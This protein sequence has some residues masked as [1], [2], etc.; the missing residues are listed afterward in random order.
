MSGQEVSLEPFTLAR[1]LAFYGEYVADPAMLDHPF[2]FDP[3]WAKRY[4]AAKTSDK[5]HRVFAVCLNG[6][7]IG[8]I[9]LKRI[10]L[11]KR[12]AT[13]SVHFSRDE[14]KNSGYGTRAEALALDY[15]FKTL[16]LSAVLADT[17]LR[18]ARSQH[19]LE[20]NGFVLTGEDEAFKY[21]HLDREKWLGG[22]APVR[23]D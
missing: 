12:E 11:E 3:E 13:L 4:H 18:N 21:Y 5:A 23:T 6:K 7:P 17:V 2:T 9:Q 22:R 16:G 8:E 14:Y 10:D 1:C 20:K 15:A 19:V